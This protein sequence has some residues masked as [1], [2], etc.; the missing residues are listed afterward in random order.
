MITEAKFHSTASDLGVEVAAIKAVAEVE[1]SGNGFL[2]SGEPKIL[3]ERHVFYRQ[4]KM[5][6]GQEFADHVMSQLPDLCNTTPGGYTKD[7]HARLQHACAIDRN[8]ALQSASWGAFQIMGYHW[9]ALGYTSLQ[10][11]INAMYRSEDEH[12]EAFEQFIRVNGLAD[13]LQRKDFVGFARIYNGPAYAKNDYP[14]KMTRAYQKFA[15]QGVK[16]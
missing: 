14:G 10:E 7:E 6:K 15:S 9:A 4:L 12:L 16:G 8:A 5:A 11:F 3:F 13:E 1:S 2:P